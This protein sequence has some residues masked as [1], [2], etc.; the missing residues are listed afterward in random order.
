MHKPF[1]YVIAGALAAV[2]AAQEISISTISVDAPD[3]TEVFALPVVYLTEEGQ[4]AVTATTLAPDETASSDP[5]ATALLNSE[6][7]ASAA[8]GTTLMSVARAK[9][10]VATC[11]PQP[12]GISHR[13]DPDTP[14]GFVEDTYYSNTALSASVP[15]GWVPS[16]V[17]LNASSSAGG[18]KGYALLD[19]YDVQ[20]CSDKC[21]SI[22][23]CNSFNIYFERDPST[24]PDDLACANPSSVI[25]V[26]CVFWGQYELDGRLF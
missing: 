11:V 18:Y 19:K 1:V 15:E 8:A 24:S 23:G 10:A 6:A 3:P 13:S 4:Q 17:N 5:R 26:K 9:R 2:A 12:T 25:N 22:T 14:I 16:F 21:R 20:T 7:I